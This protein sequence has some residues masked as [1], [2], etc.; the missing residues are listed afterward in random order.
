[1][2]TLMEHK[3]LVKGII[4][5]DK[6]KPSYQDLAHGYSKEALASHDLNLGEETFKKLADEFM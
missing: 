3:G 4:Y 5:Q 1:M 6:N 2:T